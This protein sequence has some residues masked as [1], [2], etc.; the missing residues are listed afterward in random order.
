[1]GYNVLMSEHTS[2]D[3]RAWIARYRA[4]GNVSQVCRE[5]GISR[6]TFYKWLNRS[7]PEKPSKPLR[8]QSRRPK[9]RRQRKWDDWDLK[10]LAVLDWL[11]GGRLSAAKLAQQLQ[12]KGLNLSRSTVGRMMTK[13]T[14]RCPVCGARGRRHD[15]STHRLSVDLLKWQEKINEKRRV[16]G[17]P[18][19]D[20]AS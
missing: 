13:I 1:M 7:D 17:L 6:P 18:E 10:T 16:Q 19:I 4:S 12:G 8:S 9:S 15:D 11:T 3:R 2:K 20:A 5:F 14:P